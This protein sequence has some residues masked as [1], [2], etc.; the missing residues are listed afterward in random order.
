LNFTSQ[1]KDLP[2]LPPLRQ[3]QILTKTN[4]TSYNS[5]LA[6]RLFSIRRI[7]GYALSLGFPATRLKVYP[8]NLGIPPQ[9][10]SGGSW[11]PSSNKTTAAPPLIFDLQ[12][13]LSNFVIDLIYSVS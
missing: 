8:W 13:K 5:L 11:S 7:N 6:E 2:D 4:Y 12:Y 10:S 3:L 9:T 1:Q